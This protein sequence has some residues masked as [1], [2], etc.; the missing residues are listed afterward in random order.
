MTKSVQEI[1]ERLVALCRANDTA[2]AL[3]TL[4]ADDA[5]SVEAFSQDGGDRVTKGIE[6]IGGK[7]EWWDANFEVHSASVDGPYP[8]GDDRFAVI[9]ELDATHKQSGRRSAMKEV[10]LYHV[11]DGKIVRE[12]FMYSA[13]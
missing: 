5:V 7:H 4:Y 10:A 3:S 6:G 2:T 9:F 1:G 8:S 11:A 12:E 13:N